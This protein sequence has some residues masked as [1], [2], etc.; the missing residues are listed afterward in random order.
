MWITLD[1][2][3]DN[4]RSFMFLL[5]NAMRTIDQGFGAATE[6]L[7][8]SI[9]LLPPD[10]IARQFIAD[11]SPITQEFVLVLDDFE[12]ITS[13]EVRQ[14]MNLLLEHAPATMQIVLI[15]RTDPPLQLARLRANGEL[16][17]IREQHL[18]LSRSES[19]QFYKARFDLDL[20]SIEVQQLHESTEG[21]IAGLQLMGIAFHGTP[22]LRTQGP[23]DVQ[24]GNARFADDYLWEEIFQRQP[25]D[26]RAFL[27]CTSI[28]DRFV[29]GLC[30]A[31]TGQQNSDELIRRC[32][33]DNL[34]VIQL[35]GIGAWYR[36]HRL[37]GDV[38]RNRL[39]QTM[40]D[41]QRAELHLRASR[42]FE[43][44]GYIEDAI[45]HAIAGQHWD[46]AAELLEQQCVAFF[47]WDHVAM[48]RDWLHGLPA[49]I[50]E[51][52]PQLA[53]WLAWALGR[54]GR[55]Q[56]AAQPF[57]IAEK[58]W[59]NADN[60]AGQ[61][62]LLL[63]KACFGFDRRRSII[64]AKQALDML[65]PDR[66]AERIFALSIQAIGQL[67]LGEPEKAERLFAEQRSLAAATGLTW[68]QVQEMSHSAGV[69]VQRGKLHEASILCRQVIQA[70]GD[71]P[72]QM[73]VQAALCR[74]GN[75]CF[76][77]DQLNDAS[78][79]LHRAD[80]LAEMTGS[81]QWQGRI[82]VGLA[83]IAWARGQHEATHSHLEKGRACARTT[84]NAQELRTINAWQARF[85]IASRQT[86][87][88]RQWAQD[89]GWDLSQSADYERQVEYLAY[90]RFLIW[91][92]RPGLALSVLAAFG[93]LAEAAGR[94]GDM[95]EISMLAALAHN[96]AGD[97]ASAY[98]SL[99]HS[100]ALGY[101]NDHVRLFID[102][103]EDLAPL[104]RQEALRSDHRAFVQRL[105]SGIE[106]VGMSESTGS[107]DQTFDLSER[108]IEV[109]RLAGTGMPNRE[110]GI[111]L[112]ISEA[113]VKRHMNHLLRKLGAA[114]RIQATQR[115][116][117][118]GLF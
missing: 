50:F 59:T 26:V 38:L 3:D 6:Q 100:L 93:E 86:D 1:T 95:I 19:K 79:Y 37:F 22:H 118:I 68:F 73:W 20:T 103:G 102:E 36:Y 94:Q 56:E 90:V 25:D 109:L 98:R 62:S 91:D 114:N 85:W 28:L 83:R 27:L 17:E 105:L 60:Q 96:A 30:N 11:L 82:Q 2:N 46:R 42:W 47:E 43:S 110:I 97:T 106:G 61:G 111:R 75:I 29:A 34:F 89:Y 8:V 104:L 15:S 53:F 35:D 14:A 40:T 66:S 16:L 49:P 52:S 63:W 112:F 81:L 84:G 99:R 57:Q 65:P 39:A 48:L 24:S 18:A 80:E 67:Q 115:A 113:T 7:L 23:T 92:R 32:E 5:V 4:L 77:W 117:D 54:M 108:E 116:R 72:V 33:R 64:L 87:L 58:A 76:E 31:V 9:G 21:W 55:W 10:V 101:P 13:P 78:G 69:L 44:A 41:E 51:R 107:V 71:A 12:S 74:F 70:A 45:R 88:V